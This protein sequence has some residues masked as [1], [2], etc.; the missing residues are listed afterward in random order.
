MR[1]TPLQHVQGARRIM[2]NDRRSNTARTS[3]PIHLLRETRYLSRE[4]L[5]REL[6]QQQ[7]SG[8]YTAV[9]AAIGQRDGN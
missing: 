2:S 7:L 9:K 4:E 3:Q 1:D 6:R 8:Q 5:L